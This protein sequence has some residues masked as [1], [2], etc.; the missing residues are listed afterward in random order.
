MVAKSDYYDILGLSKGA[1]VDEIKK[2]YRAEA[3]K[4]HPDKHKEDKE[5]AERR[6]KD[7]NEAYQVLS[8][9]Q[10][11][12]AYDQY[13]HDAFTPGGFP[14]GGGFAGNPFAGG[15]QHGP[16]T[17]TYTS[18]G[19]GTPFGN[20]DFGDPF[21]IFE[22]FFGGSFGGAKKQIP[23]YSM[24]I[25]FMEAINGVTKEVEIGG[26]VHKIKIPAGI[27]EGSRINFTDF[28]LSVN[29]RP[30]EL[31][32]RDGND[33]YLKLAISYSL[34]ALGGEVEVPTVDGSVKIRIR[35]GTQ[36]GTMMRLRGKGAPIL[37]IHARG[38]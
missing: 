20:F 17:Y 19:G 21:D 11:K 5:T 13:G 18:N 26:K 34:A 6:F 23:R 25:D 4:W 31:F 32:E 36:P 37:R 29:I 22:Q 9:P 12:S 7:I 15:G 30:H 1:S 8:D 14:G 38:F 27:D 35:P 16:F 2:A 28:L 3:L 33:I 24:T 10:K